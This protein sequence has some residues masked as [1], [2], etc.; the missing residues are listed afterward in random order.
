MARD[1]ERL[2]AYGPN[3]PPLDRCFKKARN[4]LAGNE[5]ERAFGCAVPGVS[6]ELSR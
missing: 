1:F 6:T 3:T 5:F 2:Q 4:D